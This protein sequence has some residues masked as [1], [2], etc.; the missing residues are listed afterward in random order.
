[1]DH[2]KPHPELYNIPGATDDFKGM[3][4][5]LLGRSGLRVANVGLGL[6]K[7]GL[8][9]TGDGARV[10]E[11]TAFKIFDRALELGATFWDTANRYNMAAGNSERVI[12]RWLKANP[13]QRRNVVLATKICGGMDGITPNHSHLSRLNIMESV[14]A[15]MARLQVDHIDLLYFHFP[16]A[17]TPAEESLAAIEDLVA[18]DLIRYFAVSSMTVAE[19]ETYRAVER[20]LTPRCRMVAVQNRFDIVQGEAS[21]CPGV[22]DYAA[23]NG[24]SFVAYSPLARG[25]LSDRYLDLQKVGPGDRLF[26]EKMLDACKN[27][28]IATKLR[29]LAGLSKEWGLELSQL[30]LAYMLALPGMGPVI[31]SSSSVKQL[32]S[33]AAAGKVKLTAEQ[34][35]RVKAAL[36]G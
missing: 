2:L 25:L 30:A 26:D 11:K 15:C 32:E 31:P 10:D 34:C 33:N 5:R 14:Y 21:E 28:A 12:G 8:P 19:L 20:S 1:M 4:Y 36:Q 17:F 24:M 3:P 23:R 29:K 13:D 35:A 16:D 6:W 27:E 7:F 22:L 9:E 18:R